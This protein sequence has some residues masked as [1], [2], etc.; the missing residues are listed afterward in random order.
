MIFRKVVPATTLVVL[1]AT[2]LASQPASLRTSDGHSDLQGIWSGATMTPLQRPK[3]FASRLTITDE[4]GRAY[5]MRDH[6]HDLGEDVSPAEAAYRNEGRAVGS[7]AS[8][9]WEWGTELSRING[10]RRTS[11]I[12]DPPDG[13]TPSRTPEGKKRLAAYF[14]QYHQADRAQDRTPMERCLPDSEIPI[15]PVGVSDI[16]QIVQTKGWV[17]IA[18]EGDARLI[19]MNAKHLPGNIRHWLGDS[20]AYW[21]GNTLVV[22]TTNFNDEIGYRA[23]SENLH[24]I[25]RLSRVDANTLLYRA[26]IDDPATFTKPWTI[27]YP[28]VAT[29]K[30][31]FEYACHEGNYSMKAILGGAR[32]SEG[33]AGAK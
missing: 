12:V 19:R 14:D 3:E 9:Y 4:E 30:Q 13:K 28:W 5:A 11:L 26:T 15:L 29:Q 21:D 2:C 22:D 27:E 17:V 18:V 32:K 6:T 20:V 24:I 31:M 33:V 8:H 1:L 10:M 16:Y 23:T 25:E 7:R